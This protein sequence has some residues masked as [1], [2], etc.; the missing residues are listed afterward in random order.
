MIV[1]LCDGRFF[2]FNTYLKSICNQM[3]NN[4]SKN[5]ESAKKKSTAK[6]GP[7]EFKIQLQKNGSN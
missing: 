4:F 3:T 7:E 2:K 6:L 5:S 1:I